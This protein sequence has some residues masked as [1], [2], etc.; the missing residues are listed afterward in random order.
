MSGGS[1]ERDI[2]FSRA[3]LAQTSHEFVAI[4]EK[5]RFAKHRRIALGLREQLNRMS[6]TA[7]EE[8]RRQAE[9]NEFAQKIMS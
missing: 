5:S 4:L 9:S 8:L 6:A 7:I 3:R 1:R 2:E